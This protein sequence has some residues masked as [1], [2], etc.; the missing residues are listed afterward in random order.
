MYPDVTRVHE[1]VPFRAARS[2]TEV[3]DESGLP[4]P[5]VMDRF[6]VLELHERLAPLQGPRASAVLLDRKSADAVVG[7]SS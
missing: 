3:S 4:A 7:C 2:V 1:A 5:A 6:P